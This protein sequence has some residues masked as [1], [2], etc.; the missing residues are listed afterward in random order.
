MRGSQI[1]WRVDVPLAAP[2]VLAGIRTATVQMVGLAA[3]TALIGA[4]GLGAIMFEGLFSSAE[5]LVLLGVIPIVALGVVADA[6]F[7]ALISLVSLKGVDRFDSANTAQ[8]A[9]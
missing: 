6:A 7:G 3:V 1:F 5:D 8:Q 2:V 4:G 9:A